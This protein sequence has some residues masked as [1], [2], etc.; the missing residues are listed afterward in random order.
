LEII[1]GFKVHPLASLFPLL[2]GQEFEDLVDAI[3]RAGTVLAVELNDGLLIDGRNR[4]RAVEE[5]RRRGIEIDLPTVDWHPAGEETVEEHIFSVN[6]HRRHL[7]DDQRVT[8]ATTFLS[9]IRLGRQARQAASRFGNNGQ[10]TVA[11]ISSPPC[12]PAPS[13]HRPRR[14]KD[15]NST[16]GQLAA[17]S[18]VSRHKADQAISLA[19]GVEAGEISRE[20]FDAVTAGRKLLRDVVPAKKKPAGKKNR[21]GKKR[22]PKTS[23]RPA[24][25][26]MF[27]VA[28]EA[29]GANETADEPAVTEDEVRRR[30]DRFKQP[31]AVVDHRDLRTLLA[32]IIAEEQQQFDR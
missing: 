27:E 25:E 30:W 1:G 22:L 31:F 17:L 29:D 7:T 26:L 9:A 4:V 16:V 6:V 19:D 24:A 14:D 3:G 32:G 11:P 2:H 18:K 21:D 8:L 15:A 10:V 13:P 12:E 23:S 28:P 20:D 5:L